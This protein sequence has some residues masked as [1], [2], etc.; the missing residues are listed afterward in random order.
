MKKAFSILLVLLATTL[1]AGC[2]SIPLGDGEQLT[3]GFDGI[4]IEATGEEDDEEI[5]DIDEEENIDDENNLGAVEAAGVQ[6]TEDTAVED[7]S[8]EEGGDQTDHSICEDDYALI[9]D[10]MPADFPMPACATITSV[11]S[12]NSNI[13]A[14]YNVE[15]DWQD[16]YKLY[17]DYFGDNIS[18]QSQKPEEKS[19]ELRSQTDEFDI[20]IQLNQRD[21]DSVAVRTIHYFVEEE[22]EE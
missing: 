6:E 8:A 9:L 3:I 11:N 15:G 4:N 19:G 20:Y 10:D 5:M 7:N 14:Y 18:S 17:Q 2:I 1:L 13:D 16:I 21:D 22:E 12:S